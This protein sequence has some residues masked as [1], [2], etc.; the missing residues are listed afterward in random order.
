MPEGGCG[1]VHF[2]PIGFYKRKNQ[3]FAVEVVVELH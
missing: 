1:W 2:R 3:K